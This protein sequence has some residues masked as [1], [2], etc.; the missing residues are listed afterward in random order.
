MV[1]SPGWKVFSDHAAEEIKDLQDKLIRQMDKCP[2]KLTGKTSFKYAHRARA[3]KEL[4]EWPVEEAR[5]EW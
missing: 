5:R 4:I 3:M 1:E 2:E